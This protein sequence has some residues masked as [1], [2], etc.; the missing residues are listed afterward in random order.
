MQGIKNT[1]GGGVLNGR[2]EKLAVPPYPAAARSA[3]AS[4]YVQV[5][6]LN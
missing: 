3:H 2:A 4:G 5:L 1:I 6:V